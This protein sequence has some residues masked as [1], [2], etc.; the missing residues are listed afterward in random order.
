MQKD[1]LNIFVVDD[2]PLARVIVVDQLSHPGFEITEFDNGDACVSAAQNHQPDIVLLDVEMPGM[3]GIEVCRRLRAD[4]NRGQVLFISAHDDIDTR[5][6]AY[7]A[8]GNDFIVKPYAPAELAQKVLVA[9]RAIEE[10][11]ELSGQARFAQQA[12]FSAM[13]SMGEMGTVLQFLQNS[14]ACRTPGQL[15]NALH[16]AIDRYGIKCLVEIRGADGPQ[17]HSGGDACTPLE[18][19]ILGHARTMGRIF[20]FRDRMA[21]NY[22]RVTLLLLNLPLDDPDR[23][24]RLRDHLA[25]IAEGAEAR[26]LALESDDRRLAQAEALLSAVTTL[27]HTL[28][29]I[30]TRQTETRLLAAEVT[31][32]YLMELEKAFIHLGLT[33]AQENT[34]LSMAEH[35]TARASAVLDIGVTLGGKLKQVTATLQEMVATNR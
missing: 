3:D 25:V 21:I 11:E 16:E 5:L 19:S 24:G 20:Q 17:C 30:E 29:E 7:E 1:R 22:E 31:S 14:F 9:R 18:V 28:E 2:D 32:D 27:T 33:S 8:G 34:L 23:I 26:L 10:R 35:A 6:A 4:G 12:A 13:S 15:A